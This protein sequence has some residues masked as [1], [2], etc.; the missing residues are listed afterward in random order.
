MFPNPDWLRRL[1]TTR[2]TFF[3]RASCFD[4][5]DVTAVQVGLVV[6][7][8]DEL[9]PRR[10]LF[11]PS[12]VRLLQ[13]PLYVQIFDEHSVVLADEPRR[14]LV[15][16]VQHLP[17]DVTF[18]FRY[19]PPL[20]LIVVRA[21]LLLR[22]L[23]LFPAQ[24]FVVVF[25]VK[26]IH[27]LPLAGVDVVENTVVNSNVLLVFRESIEVLIE[28]GSIMLAVYSCSEQ[29]IY[30]SVNSDC[31]SSS[32]TSSGVYIVGLGSSSPRS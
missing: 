24:S 29:V 17:T 12:V 7:E 2:R 5:H 32:T 22:E 26:P 9:S 31:S 30:S 8:G 15:L 3:R 10:V 11:V 19:F 18:D 27:G 6:E 25:E 1:Q 20:F 4:L 21:F 13:H 14:N 16:V 28:P 23:A